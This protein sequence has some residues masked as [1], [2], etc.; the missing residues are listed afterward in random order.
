MQPYYQ[1]FPG[2]EEEAP[3]FDIMLEVKSVLRRLLDFV[4]VDPNIFRPAP[5]KLTAEFSRDKNYL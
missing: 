1:H 3:S 4:H 2:Q 5:H